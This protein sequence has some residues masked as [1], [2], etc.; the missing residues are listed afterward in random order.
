V[1]ARVSDQRCRR[2]L[3]VVRAN[4]ATWAA[5]LEQVAARDPVPGA[6]PSIAWTCALAAAL[7][8]MVGAVALQQSPMDAIAV[9]KRTARAAVIRGA[10]LDLAERDGESYREVLAARRQRD[11]P[12]GRERLRSAFSAAADPPLAIAEL[13]AELAALAA[14]AGVAVRGGVRGEAITAA[15]LAEA[16]ARAAASIVAMNLAGFT[17]DTRIAHAE[18]LARAASRDLARMSER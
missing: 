7:V 17:G 11:E 16:A 3:T 4:E 12:N 14:D 5:L 13:A 9:A 8:E 15:V 10:A 18:A 1:A 6:G 2:R